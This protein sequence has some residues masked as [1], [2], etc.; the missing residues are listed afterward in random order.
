MGKCA[1]QCLV[2]FFLGEKP[3]G[4][5]LYVGHKQGDSSLLTGALVT[6]HGKP[7]QGSTDFS[8]GEGEI[9]SGEPQSTSAVRSA[10]T[11]DAPPGPA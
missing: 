4:T 2:W 6:R 9:Q 3:Q 7:G 10:G 8:G 1:L 5:E 11:L